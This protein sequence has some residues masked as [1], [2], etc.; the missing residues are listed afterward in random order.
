M[1]DQELLIRIDE[2]VKF[3]VARADDFEGRLRG[4]EKFRNYST[5]LVALLLI[6]AKSITF[7]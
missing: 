6:G 2:N 1:E 7:F 5:G 3:L 4:L